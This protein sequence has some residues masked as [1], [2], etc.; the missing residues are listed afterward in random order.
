MISSNGEIMRIT[1]LCFDAVILFLLLP[2]SDV[3]GQESFFVR[4][5]Q[6][7]ASSPREIGVYASVVDDSG[8]LITS[9]KQE[10][11]SGEINGKTAPLKSLRIFGETGQGIALV[12]AIDASGTMSG[13]PLDGAKKAAKLLVAKM[14]EQDYAALISFADD[15]KVHCGYTTDKVRLNNA[16]EDIA[17]RGSKTTLFLALSKILE[18]SVPSVENFPHR[19]GA[20]FV[21]DGKDEGSGI[22]IDDILERIETSGVSFYT[23]G[24]SKINRSYLDNLKRISFVSGGDYFDAPKE[25]ELSTVFSSIMDRLMKSYVLTADG[26]GI[27]MEPGQYGMSLSV[28]HNNKIANSNKKFTVSG[29]AFP[30]QPEAVKTESESSF[31]ESERESAIDGKEAARTGISIWIAAGAAALLVLIAVAIVVFRKRKASPVVV[32]E[33]Q[34]IAG[35]EADFDTGGTSVK[36]PPRIK[37]E[38]EFEHVEAETS[39]IIYRLVVKMGFEAGKVY[40]VR[41]KVVF[42]GRGSGN[43]IRLDDD[44]ISEQHAKISLYEGKLI[45][46]DLGSTNGTSVNGRRI[47]ET[48]LAENDV[49]TIGRTDLKF[50]C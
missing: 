3:S 19:R 50:L 34:S 36:Q 16:I 26:A 47:R 40:P 20:V 15:V 4:I 33:I 42:I 8:N 27:I 18:L 45:L 9:L 6:I 7:D 13:R 38:T 23:A 17:A 37:R 24:Y 22:T 14:R 31:A 10:S 28:K 46:F 21:S 49:I 25:E 39:E 5:A 12:I 43:D 32:N 44:L 2:A 30:T 11:F 1:F 29:S 41:K 35:K 48:P